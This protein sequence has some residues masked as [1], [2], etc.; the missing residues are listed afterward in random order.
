MDKN[1]QSNPALGM[2]TDKSRYFYNAMTKNAGKTEFQR[3]W[4]ARKLEDDWRRR[5]MASF[6]FVDDE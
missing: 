3:R 5:N 6:S 2:N 1:S 4:G